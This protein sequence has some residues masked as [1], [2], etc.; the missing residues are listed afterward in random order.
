MLAE[1][2]VEILA[3][4]RNKCQCARRGENRDK[5]NEPVNSLNRSLSDAINAWMSGFHRWCDDGGALKNRLSAKASTT[6]DRQALSACKFFVISWRRVKTA[7]SA[8]KVLQ[9]EEVVSTE[10]RRTGRRGDVL[11]ARLESRSND[12]VDHVRAHGSGLVSIDE[13]SSKVC[14]DPLSEEVDD[15]GMETS[16]VVTEERENERRTSPTK[17]R[18]CRLGRFSASVMVDCPSPFVFS[19]TILAVSVCRFV[20]SAARLR[21]RE[22]EPAMTVPSVAVFLN[23]LPDSAALPASWIAASERRMNVSCRSRRSRRSS[24]ALVWET[25]SERVVK[26]LHEKGRHRPQQE[27]REGKRGTNRRV[28]K[29]KDRL[30][31]VLLSTSRAKASIELH[32]WTAIAPSSRPTYA[33]RNSKATTSSL[34]IAMKME[35]GKHSE[36]SE[37][38]GRDER[39]ERTLVLRCCKLFRVEL[40]AQGRHYDLRRRSEDLKDREETVFGVETLIRKEE[41]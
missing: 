25:F 29:S 27:K 10:M 32:T 17:I 15:L 20:V 7:G 11:G 33:S 36:R 21:E 38:R 23:Q 1:E 24:S 37:K 30:T 40:V 13:E 3:V 16:S 2:A 14:E 4:R 22:D 9:C 26:H 31:E 8:S 34:H 41:G 35:R 28:G 18:S 5:E 12:V 19:E 39:S 6:T